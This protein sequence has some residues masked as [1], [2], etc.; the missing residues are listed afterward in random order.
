MKFY[1]RTVLGRAYKGSCVLNARNCVTLVPV[2]LDPGYYYFVCQVICVFG[3]WVG[4]R[5]T[6][7][8]ILRHIANYGFPSSH[9]ILFC[10]NQY[11]RLWLVYA[12]IMVYM[13]ELQFLHFCVGMVLGVSLLVSS[14]LANLTQHPPPLL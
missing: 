10:S 12:T 6:D 3:C 8:T 7:F 9:N 4:K 2:F 1:Q 11:K 14:I 13:A 5:V